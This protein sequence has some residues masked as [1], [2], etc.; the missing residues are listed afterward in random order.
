MTGPDESIAVDPSGSASSAGGR[1]AWV[2]PTRKCLEIAAK[3]HAVERSL[4]IAIKPELAA[5]ELI[6]QT[7][8]ALARRR[9]GL[10]SSARA[11]RRVAIGAEAVEQA[12]LTRKK[13]S[14][15]DIVLLLVANDAAEHSSALAERLV[16]RGCEL[17]A[18]RDKAELGS[19]FA[20]SEVA[21]AA[22]LEP[23]IA[24]EFQV[25]LDRIAGLET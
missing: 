23:Q 19:W 10:L 22:L 16:E 3:R 4:K 9:V 8:G 24:K 25:T 13:S 17:R 15:A 6:A 12:V 1:G 20:R 7:V 21:I 5:K 18:V 11:R 14:A 2:H